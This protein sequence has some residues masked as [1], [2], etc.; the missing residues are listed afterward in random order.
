MP[1]STSSMI[2]RTVR[3]GSRV[4]RF[5]ADVV[6]SAT[7]HRPGVPRWSELA[8][9]RLASGSY[10]IWKIG[11]SVVAHRPECYMVKT[12]MPSWLE[13]GEEARIHRMPCLE[14]LPEVGD[15]M[16]PQTILETTRYTVLQARDA[17]D[18]RRILMRGSTSQPV[19]IRK[20]ISALD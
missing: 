2:T 19:I 10:I 16:D 6:A 4:L 14:C 11:R 15:E 7:S 8:L 12:G 9:Y 5:E 17:D 18:V 20:I 3:D 13:A 1:G